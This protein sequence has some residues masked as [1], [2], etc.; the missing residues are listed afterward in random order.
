MQVD[1]GVE[2]FDDVGVLEGGENVRFVEER[3][4]VGSVTR[5][6][7]E[8]ECVKFLVLF[9]PREL[10]D[11]RL[12]GAEGAYLLEAIH[13]KQTAPHTDRPTARHLWRASVET[14]EHGG[15]GKVFFILLV[16]VSE[17]IPFTNSFMIALLGSRPRSSSRR[18]RACPCWS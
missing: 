12:A 6:V 8:F 1:E 3:F 5:Q 10:D 13:A 15:G 7:Y 18:P 4:G 16:H 14:R 11:P 9:P 2:V 17:F